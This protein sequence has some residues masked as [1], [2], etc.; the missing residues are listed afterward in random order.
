M[1]RG[2]VRKGAGRPPG[3]GIYGCK[4]ES[5]RI[6]VMFIPRVLLLVRKWLAEEKQRGVEPGRS[7]SAPNSEPSCLAS[8]LAP[9]RP[10]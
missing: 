2:G 4:T 9:K 6:P 10:V 1:A 3:S 8:S 7:V 5:V